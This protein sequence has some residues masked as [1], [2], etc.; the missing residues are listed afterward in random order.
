MTDGIRN[1]SL[2]DF[3]A[4][5]ERGREEARR[6]AEEHSRLMPELYFVLRH[7]GRG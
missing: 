2:D 4:R 6:W 3:E 5:M 7:S 1:E